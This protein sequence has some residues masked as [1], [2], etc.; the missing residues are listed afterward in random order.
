MRNPGWRLTVDDPEDQLL[1]DLPLR[2]IHILQGDS[3]GSAGHDPMRIGIDASEKVAQAGIAGEVGEN[4]KFEMAEVHDQE[5]L[6][7]VRHDVSPKRSRQAIE[8]RTRAREAASGMA[9]G[10]DHGVDPAGIRMHGVKER[11]D[12]RQQDLVL[13]EPQEMTKYRMCRFVPTKV[14]QSYA[15]VASAAG[16]R[17]R[18]PDLVMQESGELPC[19]RGLDWTSGLAVDRLLK[20]PDGALRARAPDLEALAVDRNA[21]LLHRCCQLP[22]RGSHM[23][24]EVERGRDGRKQWHDSMSILMARS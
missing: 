22:N 20:G 8:S 3:Q 17:K 6:I 1:P 19:V 2:F 14:L 16:R 11:P 12:L 18:K 23:A 24:F 13:L 15:R 9:V 4:P 5:Q 7:G 21:G 10:I